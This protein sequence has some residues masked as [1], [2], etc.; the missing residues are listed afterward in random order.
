MVEN[1]GIIELPIADSIVE[2]A[3][4]KSEEMGRLN[5]SI[6]KGEGN[7]AGFIGEMVVADYLGCNVD[8][9]YDYDL[10]YDS[11]KIDVK[12]KRTTAVPL[13]HY[14]CSVAAYNTHQKCD[15]YVFARV[16]NDY[17][18]VWILGCM[19]H[20]DFYKNAA[21]MKKGQLDPADPRF[22]VKADCYNMRV[23]QLLPL[24]IIK[25]PNN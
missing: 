10:T 6:T 13:P 11:V 24:S 18:K 15:Y 8:N 21:F 20:D 4:A 22:V 14:N 25:R 9:T 1:G 2:K 19:P 7:V 12:T 17:S 23:N 16:L 3:K 5:K